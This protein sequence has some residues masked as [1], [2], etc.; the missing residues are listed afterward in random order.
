[1]KRRK[2]VKV[3]AGI[4]AGFIASLLKNISSAESIFD[5]LINKI[6]NKINPSGESGTVLRSTPK[7]Q[8]K[9]VVAVSKRGDIRDKNG[10][11]RGDVLRSMFD[12]SIKKIF[13][14]TDP[15]DVLKSLFPGTDTIGIKVN[16]LAGRGLSSSR[17]LVEAVISSLQSAGIER[18]RII[19]WDRT[20]DDLIRAGFTVNRKGNDVLCFGT[21]NLYEPEPRMSGSVGSCFSRILSERCGTIINIPVLKDH[22]LAGVSLGMKNFY[23]AIHNPNK[24]HDNACNPYVAELNMHPLIKDKVRLIVCDGTTAQ[25]QG[26]PSYKP[27]WT[28]DFNGILVSE[29][30]VAIDRIG[31][32]IITEK[33]RA[34]GLKPFAEEKRDP[35]YIETAGD[36]GLGVFDKSRI[37][38]VS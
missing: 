7:I 37:K 20:D 26:G 8:K 12:E 4:S 3:T 17:E 11:L 19:V 15:R 29:D 16:C 6:N 13:G 9:P 34:A 30:P 5:T 28:W 1:M 14:V 22:D 31:F 25:F 36:M 38:I 18:E 23:G 24:Y 2:F 21:N 10:E 35:K 32:D 27:Q 33:R